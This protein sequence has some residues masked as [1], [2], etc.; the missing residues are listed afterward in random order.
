MPSKSF[1]ARFPR[2]STEE[3]ETKNRILDLFFHSEP[4]RRSI[5]QSKKSWFES[6]I[7]RGAFSP[8]RISTGSL[9]PRVLVVGRRMGGMFAHRAMKSIIYPISSSNHSFVTFDTARLYSRFSL[10]EEH[11]PR[12]HQ[13]L[14]VKA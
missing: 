6:K 11:F 4:F 1:S 14:R 12:Q 13:R 9:A 2:F 8:S 3:G 5:N 10:F 7:A